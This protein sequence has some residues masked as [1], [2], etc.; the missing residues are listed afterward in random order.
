MSQGTPIC[1]LPTVIEAIQIFALIE[2]GWLL[3]YDEVLES[4]AI[5]Q[6]ESPRNIRFHVDRRG[7]PAFIRLSEQWMSNIGS[8]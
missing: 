2:R 1:S 4:I 7:R 8:Q 6:K 5:E 3:E